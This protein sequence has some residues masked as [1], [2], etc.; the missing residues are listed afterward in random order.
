MFTKRKIAILGLGEVGFAILL[1]FARKYSVVG[2]DISQKR[3]RTIKKDKALRALMEK[4]KSI[5]I[6]HDERYLAK[7]DFYI[8]A[9]NTPLTD[10]NEPDCSYFLLA[11]K[12]VGKYL[13]Q[14]DVVVFE[15]TV[16]PGTTETLCL[17]ILESVSHLKAGRDFF[18]GFSPER[19]NPGDKKHTLINTV[20]I[21]S[22][23]NEKSAMMIKSVYQRVIAAGLYLAPNVKVAEAAKLLENLQRN[24]NIA[25][26]NEMA[27]LFHC[28]DIDVHEVVNAAK[29][30]WNFVPY[31]PGFVGGACIPINPYYLLD[32]A[33][34]IKFTPKLLLTAMQTNESM[35][36]YFFEQIKN[37]F[38]S[39]GVDIKGVRIVIFGLTYKKNYDSIAFSKVFDLI[40]FLEKNGAKVFCHDPLAKALDIKDQYGVD[41]SP[42]SKIPIFDAAVF[43]VAHDGYDDVI[44]NVCKKKLAGI[45]MVFD[46]TSSLSVDAFAEIDIKLWRF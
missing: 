28:L 14:G 9:V 22:G 41:V 12:M 3:I 32:V 26:I 15:S 29:T 21:I 45:K 43:V 42:L 24:V 5:K 39:E 17:S 27:K 1:A 7:S 33:K 37:C 46:F 25:F 36:K 10:A 4:N 34:K 16:A 40:G 44:Y 19:I 8:V 35:G 18:L 30:K 13:K 6:T 23:I 20:K 31:N 2:Y 11:A 38:A